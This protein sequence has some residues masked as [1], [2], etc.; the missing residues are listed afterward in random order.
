MKKAIES[1]KTYFRRPRFIHPAFLNN[2]HVLEIEPEADKIYEAL[3]I[4]QKRFNELV[5]EVTKVSAGAHSTLA[6]KLIATSIICKHPNELAM[7]SYVMGGIVT[8]GMYSLQ[9]H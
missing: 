3:G 4:T 7:I 8:R 9:P 1:I 5:D 2:C 6:E